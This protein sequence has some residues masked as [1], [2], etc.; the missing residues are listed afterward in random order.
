MAPK[1]NTTCSSA[2]VWYAKEGVKTLF[3]LQIEHKIALLGQSESRCGHLTCLDFP[4]RSRVP[5]PAGSQITRLD[6]IDEFPTIGGP[7]AKMFQEQ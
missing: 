7:K 6:I 2:F 4:N 5:T 1:I 3:C